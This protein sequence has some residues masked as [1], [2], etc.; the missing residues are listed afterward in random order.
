MS[1]L[2]QIF[3]QSVV[4][5]YRCHN[6]EK[7]KK[8]LLGTG[9]FYGRYNRE[10][11]RKNNLYHL[12]LVTCRHVIEEDE[13]IYLRFGNDDNLFGMNITKYQKRFL[14]GKNNWFEHHKKDLDVAVIP[15]QAPFFEHIQKTYKSVEYLKN[16]QHI[17]NLAKMND[18]G[19]TEGDSIFVIGYLQEIAMDK[20]DKLMARSGCISHIES[21]FD[22]D[23]FIIDAFTFPGNSGGPVILKPEAMS[24]DGNKPNLNAYVIGLVSDY[25]SH[26]E[27]AYLRNN[28]YRVLYD[29]NSGLTSVFNLD[30]VEEIMEYHHSETTKH[31][32]KLVQTIKDYS[33]RGNLK[34]YYVALSLK[35]YRDIIE[36]SLKD[37][38]KPILKIIIDSLNNEEIKDK[39]I[40][41]G[42]LGTFKRQTL[43]M[44]EYVN[45]INVEDFLPEENNEQIKKSLDRILQAIDD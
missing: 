32:Q 42:F 35:W 9:F 11:D 6:I 23:D 10:V 40:E 36:N 14:S 19:I 24:L 37:I 43:E 30:V 1:L 12:Y 29:D 31:V 21:L 16:D 45:W 33:F 5:I 41:I 8:T 17:A 4:A 44:K 7:K 25:Y 13:V 2:S 20:K 22:S 15:I 28:E 34:D 27:K 38:P 26:S 3:K 39:I 18:L